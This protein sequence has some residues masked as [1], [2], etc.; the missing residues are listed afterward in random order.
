MR[1]P[2]K[3]DH[4]ENFPVAS[5][6]LPAALRPAVFALYAFARSADDL[7]DEGDLPATERLRH[8]AAYHAELDRIADGQPAQ[9]PLFHHLAPLIA[10]HRLPLGPFYDLLDAFTQDVVKSRY[11]NFAELADYCRRSANPVGRLLLHLFGADSPENLNRSDALCTALQLIN[12]W[13]DVGVDL[14][15]GKSGRIYLPQDEMARF[16]VSEADLERR[17]TSAD[18]RALM[19]FQCARAR[20]LLE[21]GAP[22]GRALSGRIGMEIRAIAAGGRHILD[23]LAAVGYDV[24]A[25]RPVLGWR[26]WPRV[27]WQAL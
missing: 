15:K 18:F 13:Q 9:L 20:M 1:P 24:F 6:L 11:A 21:A 26:D 27:W 19:A 12:H 2:G 22:L 5:L 4:Y 10:A 3:P 16:G 23:K 8:L 17:R 7:A 25:R 14:A